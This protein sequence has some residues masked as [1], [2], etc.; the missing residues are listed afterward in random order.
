MDCGFT[1]TAETT[2]ELMEMVAEHAKDVHDMEPVPP[3]VAEKALSVI[4]DL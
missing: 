3:E 1:A 2:E 4:R